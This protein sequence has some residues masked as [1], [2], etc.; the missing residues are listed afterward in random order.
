ML[1]GAVGFADEGVEFKPINYQLSA[2]A[3]GRL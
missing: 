2:A 3:T 1:R